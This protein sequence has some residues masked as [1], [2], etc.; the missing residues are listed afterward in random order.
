MASKTPPPGSPLRSSP[1]GAS[2]RSLTVA[3]KEDD[4]SSLLSPPPGYKL[5]ENVGKNPP[6]K[7]EKPYPY[8]VD[9]ELLESLI[10]NFD[11]ST[12]HVVNVSDLEKLPEKP[13]P[14]MYPGLRPETI[15]IERKK[16]AEVLP[17]PPTIGRTKG[18]K[19][20]KGTFRRQKTSRKTGRRSS[21]P[22]QKGPRSSS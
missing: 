1:M 7:P 18:G 10:K 4:I 15:E 22:K 16:A 2:P 6:P 21:G 9:T 19:R 3:T 5:P 20:R 14:T 11:T 17:G 8:N 13:A 12:P